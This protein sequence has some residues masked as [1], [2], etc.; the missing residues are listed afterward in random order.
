M[1]VLP[2]WLWLRCA[3]VRIHN[4]WD[5]GVYCFRASLILNHWLVYLLIAAEQNNR[6]VWLTI[7]AAEAI[8]PLMFG[9]RGGSTRLFSVAHA[10]RPSEAVSW[11]GTICARFDGFGCQSK[12]GRARI[13]GNGEAGSQDSRTRIVRTP[14]SRWLGDT[15][16]FPSASNQPLNNGMMIVL[17]VTSRSRKASARPN[18]GYRA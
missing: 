16:T 17:D 2:S 10:E 18:C 6:P 7:V 4:R 9:R 13:S 11:T 14:P 3:R 1:T 8:A 15:H 5:E 12:V